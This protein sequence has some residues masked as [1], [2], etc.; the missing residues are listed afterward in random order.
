MELKCT[1]DAPDR[2][3]WRAW[4]AR[5]HA[6]Q[7]EV[8]LIYHKAGS[9]QPSIRYEDS[10]EEALCFGWVDSLVQNIDALSH[11]RKFTPR[12][13]GSAWSEANKRRAA[14]AIAE[15]RMT[16][17]GLAR[18]DFPLDSAPAHPAPREITIPAWLVLG[19]QTSPQ[20][21]KNFCALPPSHQQRYVGWLSSA[22]REATR[23]K[24]LQEALTLLEANR[25][26]GIGP[27]EVRK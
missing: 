11:A 13:P 16:P 12:R 18:I 8:W 7:P 14:K 15:G 5:N 17:A 6:T 9:G 3:G 25:R 23:Q 4:L 19:L 10:V 22:R 26:L 1:F 20:A 24:R 21:W 2:A 27:G